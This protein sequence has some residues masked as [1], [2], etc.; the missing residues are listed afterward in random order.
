MYEYNSLVE[1]YDIWSAAD[2]AF[3]PSYN[4]YTQICG[5]TQGN[6]VELGVGTGRI[7]INIAKNGKSI[8]GIDI[9]SEMLKKCKEKAKNE[10]VEKKLNLI[11]A[12]I[13][14]FKLPQEANLII[15]PFRTVGHL[16]TKEDKIKAFRK[17]YNNLKPGG[18]F[19]F[20]HYIFD[21]KWA[22]S[23][24]G[25]PRLMKVAKDSEQNKIFIWDIYLY[26][27]ISQNMQCYIIVEKTDIMGNVIHK[28]YNP[29]SFSWISP[30]EVRTIASEIG[31][32]V[33]ALYGDFQFGSFDEKSENQVWIFKREK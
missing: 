31:F 30:D 29:L 8:T 1:I 5:D 15:L 24:D 21:E 14:N 18:K 10:D 7:A 26:N 25:I 22:R 11:Q 16:L 19:V 17:I 12:N 27:F 33:E 3:I 32:N 28:R 9:S 2:P 4:F 13:L 6:I 23:Y 20:D